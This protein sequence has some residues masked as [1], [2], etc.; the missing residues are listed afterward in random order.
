MKKLFAL[1]ALTFLIAQCAS[2]P[3]TL[4]QKDF[5]S[6]SAFKAITEINRIVPHF[7]GSGPTVEQVSQI[8]QTPME[9]DLT[10]GHWIAKLDNYHVTGRFDGDLK[11]EKTVL[12]QVNFNFAPNEVMTYADI[13]SAFGTNYVTT[14][15]TQSVVVRQNL[16]HAGKVELLVHLSDPAEMVSQ[17]VRSLLLRSKK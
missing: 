12:E 3:L 11:E 13:Q 2:K 17:P 7:Q 8:L 4:E 9:Y 1:F 16:A 10:S 5:S 14:R 15:H 6:E